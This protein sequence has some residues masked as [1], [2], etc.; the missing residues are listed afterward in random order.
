MTYVLSTN[1]P[2]YKLGHPKVRGFLL[3]HTG[4]D[5]PFESTLRKG[6]V[7]DVYIQTLNKI[8]MYV[9]GEKNWVSIDETTDITG[10]Y[11]ANVIIGTLEENRPSKIF[12]LNVEE[13]QKANHSTVF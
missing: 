3:K 4:K 7:D 12:L 1:I 2:L 10:R 11:V 9:N 8:R 6:Y 13:L 5:I